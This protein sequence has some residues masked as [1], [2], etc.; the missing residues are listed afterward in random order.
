[1][2]AIRALL[3]G[4]PVAPP[5]HDPPQHVDTR[6]PRVVTREG[7]LRGFGPPR[8]APAGE[9]PWIHDVIHI[10]VHKGIMGFLNISLSRTGAPELLK[11]L[12]ESGH[13]E[14]AA[15]WDAVGPMKSLQQWKT[16]LASLNAPSEPLDQAASKD[17]IGIFLYQYLST[18]DEKWATQPL[19]EAPEI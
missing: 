12:E 13:I 1:M 2:E 7:G 6:A 9:Q 4:R 19:Q 15:W 10:D 18:S 8:T 5:R 14:F 11:M 16:K 3:E 17:D